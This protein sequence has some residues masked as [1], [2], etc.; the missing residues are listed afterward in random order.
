MAERVNRLKV[1][2]QHLKRIIT[3]LIATPLLIAIIWY[4]PRSVFLLVIL[5]TVAVSLLEYYALARRTD[6]SLPVYFGI[7]LGSLIVFSSYSFSFSYTL[8]VFFLVTALSLAY[9]LFT[10]EPNPR[11]IYSMGVFITGLV[12]VAFFLSHLVLIRHLAMGR[13]WILFL[14]AVVFAGDAGAY[15]VGALLGRHK[16]YPRVSP[17]KTIEGAIG[18]LAASIGAAHL[19]SIYFFPWI[20]VRQVIFLALSLGITAQIGDLVESMF[21]RSAQ[22]KDSGKLFPGHGGMLDRMDGVIL[23]APVLFYELV[24][25]IRP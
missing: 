16:L 24:F 18:G 1:A 4:G 20:T 13:I 10:Y 25:F 23:A 8:A 6:L 17:G 12:Y 14:L 19:M 21:K 7:L 15:C 2:M 22:V 5:V 3:A 11:V 9:Y